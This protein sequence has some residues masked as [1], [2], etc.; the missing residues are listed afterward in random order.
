MSDVVVDIDD[1]AMTIEE[2]LDRVG[3]GAR[4]Y[5]PKAVEKALEEG[6]DK[7]KDN[8]TSVL[9]HSYSRGGWGRMRANA[10]RFK[11]GRHEGKVKASAWYG[12]V[13]KTGKYAR[14]IKH[15]MLSS[16]GEVFEGEIGSPTVP[17]LAHLLEKG[18]AL[19]GG[20][21]ARAHVHIATAAED[22]F[23]DLERYVEEAIEEAISEA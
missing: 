14:S 19:V 6:R 15:H 17:G 3:N 16:G 11:S 4:H 20:G 5:V 18:H 21:S 22:V 2:I 13:I 8:A 9:S 10:A 7:W 1:F 23:K 12:R